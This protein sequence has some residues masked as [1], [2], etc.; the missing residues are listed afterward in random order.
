MGKKEFVVAVLHPEYE[1]YIVYIASLSSTPLIASFRFTPLNIHLSQKPR[2]SSLIIEEA[3]TKVSKKYVHFTDIFF[4]DLAIKLPEHIGINDY[5]IKLVNG[6]KRT[7]G[8]IY[9]LGSVELG[10]LK[11]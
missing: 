4:L 1:T 10:N 2:I 9:S 8:P 11:A 5:A 6:Q 3:F 7:Y